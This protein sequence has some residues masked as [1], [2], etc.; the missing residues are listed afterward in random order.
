M[1]SRL[2]AMIFV[3]PELAHNHEWLRIS[4]DFTVD[5]FTAMQ[6]VKRWPKA[7]YYLATFVEPRCIRLK[8]EYKKA[9]DV[10]RPVLQARKQ[11]AADAKSQGL[12]EPKYND[13]IEW[14]KQS[15]KGID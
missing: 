9:M 5:L 14:F 4:V 12:P 15:S 6:D 8:A 1:V 2:S 3:G 10:L 7:L 13:S 11:E